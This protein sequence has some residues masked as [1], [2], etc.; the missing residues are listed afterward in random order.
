MRESRALAGGSNRN[1][2]VGAFGDLPVHNVAEGLF[3]ERAVFERRD[4]RGKRASKAR[5]SGHGATSLQGSE[6]RP[7]RYRVGGGDDSPLALPKKPFCRV[8]AV[9]VSR[10]P[11]DEIFGYHLSINLA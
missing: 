6:F 8:F 1:Q 9:S 4:Q 10:V 7:H 3:V 5:L 11:D 2:A